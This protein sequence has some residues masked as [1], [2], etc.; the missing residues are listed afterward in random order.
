MALEQ[1]A[2][3]RT[4]LNDTQ[5]IVFLRAAA[6]VGERPT[7]VTMICGALDQ[8]RTLDELFV[9]MEG[10]NVPARYRSALSLS[11]TPVGVA[12]YRIALG[13]RG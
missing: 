9:W 13:S 8:G 12:Q 10:R 7:T 11:V 4:H 5:L 1:L 2:Q 6:K 3:A